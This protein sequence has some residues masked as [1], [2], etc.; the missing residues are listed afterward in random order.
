LSHK[1]HRPAGGGGQLES[2]VSF[3]IAISRMQDR[4]A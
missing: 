3:G 2:I 1:S 4:H